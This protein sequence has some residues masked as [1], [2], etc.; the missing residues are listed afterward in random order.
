MSTADA[1]AI[2]RRPGQPSDLLRVPRWCAP[3]MASLAVSAGWG[4]S[5]WVA[6][7]LRA[8]AALHTVALFV[9]LASL[10]I[11]FGAVL[12]IDYYGVLW[13]SGRKSL[14]DVVEYAAPLHL[15]VWAGLAGLIASGAFLHPDLSSPLTCVKLGLVLLLALNGVQAGVL[16]RR[17]AALDGRPATR[18]L[19]MRGAATATVSQAAWWGAVA[20]GFLNSRR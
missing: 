5:I 8:D 7:H 11:G 20:I 19:L 17:L 15:P 3:A 14:R 18:A 12:V 6:L 10:V 9:H 2:R 1:A 4:A 16:H 13:L